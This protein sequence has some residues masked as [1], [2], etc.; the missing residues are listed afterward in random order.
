[1]KLIISAVLA[2]GLLAALPSVAY[3]KSCY[4]LWYERNEI[5]YENGYCFSTDLAIDTFGNDDCYTTHPH[6]S[7]SEQRRINQI[8]AERQRQKP[9]VKI[10]SRYSDPKTSELTFD[11]VASQNN[12]IEIALTK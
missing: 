12:E 1:M 6:F 4:D 7:K 2:T 3:A 8:V 5:Y 11:I 9:P 10:P